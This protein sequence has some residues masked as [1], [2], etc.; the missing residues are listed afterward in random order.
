MHSRVARPFA[1]LGHAPLVLLALEAGRAVQGGAGAGGQRPGTELLGPGWE[2]RAGATSRV[3]PRGR[4]RKRLHS[5]L[6]AAGRPVRPRAPSSS[7]SAGRAAGRAG[8]SGSSADRPR[9]RSRQTLRPR[10][11]RRCRLGRGCAAQVGRPC[12]R[13]PGTRP[14]SRTGSRS[15]RSPSSGRPGTRPARRRSRRLA[16]QSRR[17]KTRVTISP[18]PGPQLHPDPF[19]GLQYPRSLIQPTVSPD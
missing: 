4:H 8:G 10:T 19:S 11:P 17:L 5:A 2:G 12:R 14:R 9:P 1:A 6:T 7:W 13:R 15:R 16:L 18:Q 3:R